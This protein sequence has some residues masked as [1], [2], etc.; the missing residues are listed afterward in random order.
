[1]Y[2]YIYKI[3]NLVN[4][5]QYIGQHASEIFDKKYF[6]SGKLLIKAIQKYGKENFKVDI[7]EWCNSQEQLDKQEIY[8]ISYYDAVNSDNFYNLAIGG[9]CG[10]RKGS[11]F[12][13]EAKKHCSEAHK[14]ENLSEKTLKRMSESHKGL[15][16]PNKGKKL[17]KEHKEKISKSCKNMSKEAR[18]KISKSLLGNTRR[19]GKTLSDETKQKLSIA[20]KGRKHSKETKYKQSISKLGENNPNYNKHP[21]IKT[22][23]KMSNSHKGLEVSL[24]ARQ[25]I[26]IANKGRIVSDETKQKL[27]KNHANV[28]GK[29]N[30]CYGKI[31]ITNGITNKFIYLDELNTYINNGYHKGQTKKKNNYNTQM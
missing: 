31:C 25:K 23:Q 11:K 15:P 21:S 9:S 29:N 26:S 5:K 1:M 6:G 10:N 3:T 30:P 7:I 16:S 4:N 18:S 27:S 22:R 8:W 17:S 19:R 28:S 13:A 2:G 24:E 12:S 20:G 14:K